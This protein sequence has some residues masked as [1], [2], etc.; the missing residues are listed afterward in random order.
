MASGGL[1][2]QSD[3]VTI[4]RAALVAEQLTVDYFDLPGD[5]WRRNRYGVFTRKV[6]GDF[7]YVDDVFAHLIRF[8]TVKSRS[9]DEQGKEESLGI[10]LQDP[11]ILRALLRS[12]M[13]DLWT[14]ALFVLTH[15]LV[16]IVRFRTF[17]VDLFT[18]E[19]DRQGEEDLVHEITG[20]ILSGVANMDSLLQM[21][22]AGKPR[23]TPVL[24]ISSGRN[25]NADLRISVPEVRP[26]IRAM[27]E[28]HRSINR[29]M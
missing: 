28:D 20:E 4:G 15:E 25:I 16:H 17:Q 29:P 26:R 9:K 2:T 10:L 1:F 5:E 13:H 14:L 23:T 19:T 18:P 6:A 27:A 12:R 21:Y 7:L 22:E 3:L 24:K 11:N 8:K